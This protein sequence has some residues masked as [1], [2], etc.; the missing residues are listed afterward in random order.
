[1]PVRIVFDMETRDPDDVLAL[2]L[3]CDHPAVELG[4]V[5]LNIACR[6]SDRTLK[7]ERHLL[8]CQ[9]NSWENAGERVASPKSPTTG[10]A[11]SPQPP[12]HWCYPAP[13]QAF[14][15]APEWRR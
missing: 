12:D 15:G 10:R 5:T 3:L 6:V 14:P 11:S 9:P 4:A 2:C 8:H 7:E 1:M 13:G